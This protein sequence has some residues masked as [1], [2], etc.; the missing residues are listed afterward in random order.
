MVPLILSKIVQAAQ[1]PNTLAGPVG[2]DADMRLP[3]STPEAASAPI[4]AVAPTLAPP[5]PTAPTPLDLISQ[6]AAL[7]QQA[8]DARGKAAGSNQPVAPQG[9][10]PLQAGIAAVLA[11]LSPGLGQGAAQGFQQGQ[12]QQGQRKQE[13]NNQKDVQAEYAARGM[14]MHAG[15]L[16]AQA[17]Q[18]LA[19]QRA[20][21]EFAQQKELAG[22][23]YGAGDVK[24]YIKILNNPKAD[25]K[26]QAD[27]MESL[28]YINPDRYH[29]TDAQIA[30]LRAQPWLFG[31]KTKSETDLNADKGT[32]ALSGAGLNEKKGDRID[33]QNNL[34]THRE[35]MMDA[36]AD[37]IRGTMAPTIRKLISE[38]KGN[39]VKAQLDAAQAFAAR[40]RG[41]Y[42]NTQNSWY[43]KKM[44]AD[45]AD[46]SLRANAA[47]TQANAATVRAQNQLGKAGTGTIKEKDYFNLLESNQKKI[48]AVQAGITQYQNEDD[49]LSKRLDDIH[50]HRATNV[51]ADEEQ[52]ITKHLDAN[53]ATLAG[54]HAMLSAAVAQHHRIMKY[55]EDGQVDTKA[56]GEKPDPNV[57]PEQQKVL[58]GFQVSGGPDTNGSALAAQ[59]V[60]PAPGT[61]PLQYVGAGD[62]SAPIK[63]PKGPTTRAALLAGFQ[64]RLAAEPGRRAELIAAAAKLGLR[65]R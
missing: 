36:R 54:Y 12:A 38:A 4:G 20:A 46:A 18:Q 21:T 15:E 47:V 61:G 29:Y 63:T 59:A 16:E 49:A 26:M 3:D 27:A 45:I 41:N 24:E 23:R 9:M 17:N 6:A 28:N 62:L 13:Q 1:Q 5:V 2:Q 64:K 10:N 44:A 25:P 33:S 60:N 55:R 32:L 7:R 65:L 39:D 58:A 14:E 22:I 34:D 37:F 31:D 50:N 56:Y 48:D 30:T 19:Q 57:T 42:T 43:P 40:A 35:N 11:S 8:N 51:G 53:A 52:T